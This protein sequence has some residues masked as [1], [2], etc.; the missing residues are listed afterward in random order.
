MNKFYKN[1]NKLFW[2]NFFNNCFWLSSVVTFFYLKRDL[3]YAE[4]LTLSAVLSLTV[5]LFEIPTGIIADKYGR[6]ISLV[7]S[8]IFFMFSM[9]IYLL[10]HNFW[11]FGLA[12]VL[13]GIGITFG[14]GATEALI[15]DSLKKVNK[16]SEMR[17]SMG[18]FM[19]AEVLA[20]MV[21]PPIA[22][23]IAKDL[24]QWQ[25]NLLIYFTIISYF[26]AFILILTLKDIKSKKQEV[27]K[28]DFS[29]NDLKLLRKNHKFT[30]LAINKILV[31]VAMSSFVLLWQPQFQ[32]SGVPIKLF[33]IF[34]ALG[35]FGIFIVNQR[36]EW[37]SKIAKSGTLLFISSIA[38][39]IGFILL[40]VILNPVVSILVYII[41]RIIVSIREP[42]LSQHINDS[43]KSKKR[44]AILSLISMI[45]ALIAFILKP[46][47]GALT[48]V[49]LTIGFISL[50]LLCLIA[51]IIFPVKDEHTI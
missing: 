48:D 41:L 51:I 19:S 16:K 7:F 26:I 31:G 13:L 42:I 35:S 10:A 22:S 17:K 39:V 50:S 15:Y 23:F 3:N 1:I 30:R 45:S 38:A 47:I 32:A 49:N 29:F 2:V 21:T 5:L 34:L 9:S 12:F 8:S 18:H 46:V 28:F 43:I 6:K 14:S 4:I 37:I 44:A 33:G 20:G 11:L 27:E 36:I 40:G 25:F 24:L